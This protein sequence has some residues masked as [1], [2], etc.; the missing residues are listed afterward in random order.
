MAKII[1]KL[2]REK[3]AI[4]QHPWLFSG[5]IQNIEGS[6]KNGELVQVYSG[7][8]QFLGQGFFNKRTSI[9][10]RFLSFTDE[11][12][13][14]DFWVRKISQA[15]DLRRQIID[16][17]T[18]N[19]YRLIHSEGDFLPGLVVDKYA[20]YLSLQV[21]SAGMEKEKEVIIKILCEILKPVGIYERSDMISR[22]IEGLSPATGVVFGEVPDLVEIKENGLKFLVDLKQGQKTGLFLD[23][24]DSRAKVGKYSAGKKVLNCFSYTG[25][26]SVYAAANQAKQTLSIELSADALKLTQDNFK[27]NN[28]SLENNK[29]LQADV[30]DALRDLRKA[31]QEKFDLIILDP[32]AFTKNAESVKTAARGYKD[33]N[34][35]ALHLASPNS[36][37]VTCSCSQYI[38]QMLFQKIV[39]DAAR[40]AQRQLQILEIW[41]QAADH[42]VSIAHPEGRYLK[43]LFCRVI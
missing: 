3:S 25:G 4:N 27:L 23:Q 26:F 7:K 40:D 39:H 2:G 13:N 6:P 15:I 24:R 16:P 21:S 35:Q 18:T 43:S 8:G 31:E 34:F 11:P 28:L 38:D 5:A 1:L 14:N 33:I 42:P 36:L 9:S 30:F 37:F 41:G 10:V 32:P 12:I 29:L 20:D 19:A 17:A 22:K